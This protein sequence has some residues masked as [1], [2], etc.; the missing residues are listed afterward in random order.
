MVDSILQVG[1]LPSLY[2]RFEAKQSKVAAAQMSEMTKTKINSLQSESATF[3]TRG[4]EAKKE[5]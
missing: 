2:I 4:Y 1:G 5:K 3:V